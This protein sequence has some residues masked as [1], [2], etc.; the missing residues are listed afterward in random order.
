MSQYLSQDRISDFASRLPAFENKVFSKILLEVGNNSNMN[1]L[2][3]TIQLL[4]DGLISLGTFRTKVLK[5][6]IKH[7]YLLCHSLWRDTFSDMSTE[8]AK[9]LA[10][11]DQ[12][13]N[14]SNSSGEGNSLVYGDIDF[15]SFA[16]IMDTVHPKENDTFTDLGHGTGRALLCAFLLYGSILK[17]IIGIEINSALCEVSMNRV[18]FCL[19]ETESQSLLFGEHCK[20]SVDIVHGDMLSEEN[21]F[22]T[23]SGEIF[24]IFSNLCFTYLGP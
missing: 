22:W 15:N 20:C 5:I 10:G 23:E 12:S 19:R 4:Q 21:A 3:D 8:R 18:N 16:C 1:E 13:L 6:I 7:S 9:I 17:K 14:P 24:S 2:F 11:N